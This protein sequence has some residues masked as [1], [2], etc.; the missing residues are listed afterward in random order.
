MTPSDPNQ[1][2]PVRSRTDNLQADI[3]IDDGP[4]DN[5]VRPMR[6]EMPRE[7]P[8]PNLPKPE[9]PPEQTP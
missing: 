8:R 9:T 1:S 6:P 2:R 5:T 3:V 7:H 4:G